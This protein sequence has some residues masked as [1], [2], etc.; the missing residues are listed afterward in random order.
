MLRTRPVWLCLMALST[1]PCLAA[2]ADGVPL[3]IKPVMDGGQA[4]A[5]GTTIAQ[6]TGLR[7][8]GDGFLSIRSAPDKKATEISRLKPKDLVI[9]VIPPEGWQ[10]ADYVGAIFNASGKASDDMM[11]DCKL[12]ETQPYFEG[13][14]KGPCQTGWVARRFVTVLAD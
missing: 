11:A 14:Y 1:A 3:M 12:T 9:V 6:V 2:A 5:P 7:E 4:I 8:G 10:R 13:V